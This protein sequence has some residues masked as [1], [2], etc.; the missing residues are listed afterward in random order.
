MNACFFSKLGATVSA[1]AVAIVIVSS[2]CTNPRKDDSNVAPGI[3]AIVHDTLRAKLLVSYFMETDGGL[4][5]PACALLY[6]EFIAEP[7]GWCQAMQDDTTAYKRFISTLPTAV[8]K[9]RDSSISIEE[10]TFA[11]QADLELA[12]R[13]GVSEPQQP[14]FGMVLKDIETIVPSVFK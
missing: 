7:N 13:R 2:G 3:A 5:F 4:V 12:K 1:I 11:K 10:L 14:F 8:F 9:V 6:E